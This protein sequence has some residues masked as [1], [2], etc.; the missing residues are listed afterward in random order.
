MA[1]KS[2]LEA[3]PTLTAEAFAAAQESLTGRDLCSIADLSTDEVAT[4]LSLAHRVKAQPKMFRYAL[5]AKQTV[6]FF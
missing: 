1:T 6:M 3:T 4:I 5:D 2:L